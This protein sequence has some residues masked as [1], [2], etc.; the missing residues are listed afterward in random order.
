M[1]IYCTDSSQKLIMR[2]RY[3]GQLFSHILASKPPYM[4]ATTLNHD[5]IALCAKF[6]RIQSQP[7]PQA[8]TRVPRTIRCGNPLA[9]KRLTQGGQ[10]YHIIRPKR[11]K[12][13]SKLRKGNKILLVS[14]RRSPQRLI[15]AVVQKRQYSKE[16]SETDDKL[17][18]F[19]RARHTT[20][21]L[22]LF[23]C[24]SQRQ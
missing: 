17:W 6:N 9:E 14:T 23:L 24:P 8:V 11:Q 21:D 20:T 5:W 2:L 16:P 1:T 18:T 19:A 15:Y 10:R 22:L 12:I 4:S 13:D 3:D 7:T